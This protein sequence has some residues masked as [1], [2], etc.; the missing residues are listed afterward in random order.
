MSKQ[1]DECM[2]SDRQTEAQTSTRRSMVISTDALALLQRAT[3]PFEFRNTVKQMTSEMGVTA[4][5]GME[6]ISSLSCKT[7]TISNEMLTPQM[8]FPPEAISVTSN[9]V[10]PHDISI[11]GMDIQP[12][13][14]T[15]LTLD[16]GG[17]SHM[18]PGLGELATSSLRW[19]V[20]NALFGERVDIP[21]F[22]MCAAGVEVCVRFFVIDL[23]EREKNDPAPGILKGV[24][25]PAY[26]KAPHL[27]R[28]DKSIIEQIMKTVES[29]NRIW[30]QCQATTI[31]FTVS[32]NN[33]D[34]NRPFIYALDATQISNVKQN[35]KV[36][37]E[38]PTAG[39]SQTI[40][41]IETRTIDLCA[42]FDKDEK[43]ARTHNLTTVDGDKNTTITY[44]FT[45]KDT[46]PNNDVLIEQGGSVP[47]AILTANKLTTKK[48]GDFDVLSMFGQPI[49]LLHGEEC[50]NVFVVGN[51]ED[52]GEKQV[53]EESG[54]AAEPGRNIILDENVISGQKGRILAHEFGHNLGLPH[55][56]E[57]NLMHPS[58]GTAL[59]EGGEDDQCSKAA[60]QA[61]AIPGSKRVRNER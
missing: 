23:C 53:G 55:D 47:D 45:W 5:A 1:N 26:A 27:G 22:M 38:F 40:P 21:F 50:I 33:E 32:T 6:N 8:L 60:K 30:A 13:C 18:T 16:L 10:L 28:L 37:V 46:V 44:K 41:I 19:L 24:T 4:P 36:L 52:T 9:P 34:S 14:L 58:T 42:L 29:A 17:V 61:A 12:F 20:T 35:D 59:R 51:F 11:S 25:Y 3:I 39:R 43:G 15:N 31:R 48:S 56:K 54:W 7:E 57:G 2:C 49:D